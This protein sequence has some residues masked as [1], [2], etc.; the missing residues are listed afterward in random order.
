MFAPTRL[1]TAIRPSASSGVLAGVGMVTVIFAATP[2]LIPTVS[3]DFGVALG[4]AGFLSTAQVAG[5]AAASFVAGRMGTSSRRLLVAA[6]VALGVSNLAGAL[7]MPFLV[8]LV[9]R[10]LAGVTMG[11]ITWIAWADATRHERGLGDVAAIGPVAAMLASPAMAWLADVGGHRLVYAVMG[12][13]SLL[14]A[15]IPSHVVS[16]PP[17]GR[18]VSPSR[19]NRVLLGALMLFTLAGSSLFMFSAVTGERAGLSAIAVSLAF[20]LNALAGIFGTRFTVAAGSA[21]RW[22]AATAISAVAVGLAPNGWVYFAAMAVWGFSF[23]AA[24]PEV[25]R[26]LAA[27]SLR[28]DE[29]VGDAQSLMGLGRVLGPALGGIVL[30]ADRFPALTAAAATGLVVSA[31]VI[32]AVEHRRR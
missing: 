5:F 28:P 10:F 20:S 30:G 14:V 16:Q 26:M 21:W 24:I 27:R 4:T 17:V 23:W 6:S 15:M 31:V 8:L 12:G 18:N 1:L 25:F 11:V 32:G 22:M 2:F 7:T 13:L 9:T 29:R 3:D 19:S